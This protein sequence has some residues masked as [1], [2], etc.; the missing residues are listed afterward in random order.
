MEFKIGGVIAVS[1]PAADAFQPRNLAEDRPCGKLD[2]MTTPRLATATPFGRMY[3]RSVSSE[4]L[5]PSITTVIAQQPLD[6]GGWH[7]HM[8]AT[9]LANHPQLES[10]LNRPSALRGLIKDAAGAAERYRDA[11]A[12]RGD[13]IHNYCE[14]VALKTMGRDHEL[15]Q[16]LETLRANGEEAYAQR[17]DEWWTAFRVEPLAAEVTVWNQT[18]GYAGTLDLV[19]RIAG[20]VCL[21]DYKTKGTDRAGRVKSLDPKVVMQLTAG[22]KA[23]E[24]IVDADTGQWAPWEFGQAEVLM[25]VALGETEVRAQRANPAHLPAYWHQFVSLRRSWET[26]KAVAELGNPLIEL[27][28]PAP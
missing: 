3:A 27:P 21:I 9:E 1:H 20:R 24:Q 11:A 26:S 19:A 25:G 23:E 7:G 6:L 17:F 15:D 5:V 18:V 10:A 8:A 2:P 28:P 12:E 14:Q 22:F 4:P 13:R 16:A